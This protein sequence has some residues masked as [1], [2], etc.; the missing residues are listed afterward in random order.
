MMRLF[1][2]ILGFFFLKINNSENSA[3]AS[4]EM[5]RRTEVMLRIG[6]IVEAKFDDK[7]KPSEGKTNW[8]N[9]DDSGQYR[10]PL[11]RVEFAEK[12]KTYWIRSLAQRAGKDSDY[13]TYE[14]GEQVM[15]ACVDGNQ[16]NSYILGAL[17]Q[18]S[19]RPP[20]GF[21]DETPDKRPWRS[22]VRR[23]RFE[24][25][26]LFEYDKEKNRLLMQFLGHEKQMLVWN[27]QEET[28]TIKAKTIVFE[29]ENIILKNDDPEK[30]SIFV[31]KDI[32]CGGHNPNKHS[33]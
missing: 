19:Y 11:Y 24:D 17:Y 33:H 12:G 5:S 22:S 25:K 6:K 32:N 14:I 31:Q 18:D 16:M 28:L 26:T 4:A 7:N 23:S 10:G 20:Q 30:G 9:I 15:V 3:Y 8:S 1:R 2:S 27:A 29:S 13:W 21:D